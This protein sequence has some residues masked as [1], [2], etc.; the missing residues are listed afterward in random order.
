MQINLWDFKKDWTSLFLNAEIWID[1]IMNAQE[2]Q[3]KLTH[4]I[5]KKKKLR[6]HFW[7]ANFGTINDR[8]IEKWFAYGV[9]CGIKPKGRFNGIYWIKLND[10]KEASDY[11][12]TV[13][14]IRD[15]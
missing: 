3:I 8:S 14:Y 11:V 4:K 1:R 2:T 7:I 15:A 10:E 5:W 6:R 12:E 9:F 13:L